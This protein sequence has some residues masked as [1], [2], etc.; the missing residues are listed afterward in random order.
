[1]ANYDIGTATGLS[2]DQIANSLFNQRIDYLLQS[3]YKSSES[4]P[5]ADSSICTLTLGVESGDATFDTL[6][7]FIEYRNNPEKFFHSL[8]LQ[9]FSYDLQIRLGTVSTLQ[10]GNVDDDYSQILPKWEFYTDAQDI[11]L[12][13]LRATEFTL[14]VDGVYYEKT[15]STAPDLGANLSTQMLNFTDKRTRKITLNFA[16]CAGGFRGV[17]VLPTDSV[18]V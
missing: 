1:M 3:K 5:D 16:T 7:N 10:T 15:N 14:Q 2:N 13:L 18:L 11:V 8:A 17:Y 12:G 6:T 9:E 4:I